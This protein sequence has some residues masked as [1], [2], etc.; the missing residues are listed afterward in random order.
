MRQCSN[1]LCTCTL[2]E[3]LERCP[4]CGTQT[5]TRFK[6]LG[7][8]S[9]DEELFEGPYTVTFKGHHKATHKAVAITVF[10]PECQLTDEEYQRLR[11]EAETMIAFTHPHIPMYIAF[12]VTPKGYVFRVKQ[13]IPFVPFSELVVD[14]VQ[15]PRMACDVL[16]SIAEAMLKMHEQDLLQPNL[17][18]SDILLQPQGQGQYHTYFNYRTFRFLQR[19][20]EEP[21]PQ[22]Q[23]LIQH[24]PDHQP[25][26]IINKQTDL[27]CLG[28][29]GYTLLTGQLFH[30]ELPRDELPPVDAAIPLGL[31]LAVMRLLQPHRDERGTLEGFL[32]TLHALTEKDFLHAEQ[33]LQSNPSPPRWSGQAMVAMVAVCAALL[34][35]LVWSIASQ[36]PTPSPVPAS[37]VGTLEKVAERSESSIFLLLQQTCTAFAI[38]KTGW[39]VTSAHC[40]IHSDI[41]QVQTLLNQAKE[42]AWH[43]MKLKNNRALEQQ[44]TYLEFVN[45]ERDWIRKL[46][47][48]KLS[49]LSAILPALYDRGAPRF[50]A[51]SP[52][53]LE[54]L[55]IVKIVVHPRYD[56]GQKRYAERLSQESYHRFLTPKDS[57]YYDLALVKVKV[58]SSQPFP[59]LS[60][61]SRRYLERMGRTRELVALHYGLGNA[62]GKET[63]KPLSVVTEVTLG[64]FRE[65]CESTTQ[66]ADQGW[67]SSFRSGPCGVQ[68]QHKE[69]LPRGASGAPLLNAKGEVVGVVSSGYTRVGYGGYNWAVRADIL[70]DWLRKQPSQ[71]QNP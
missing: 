39:L 12:G 22:L 64:V 37:Q 14:G 38:D 6:D 16:R 34:G 45:R 29:V 13:W 58:P 15:R 35:Y 66:K 62:G 54:P 26:G 68:F 53:T 21:A 2:G 28:M 11:H 31:W 33:R 8:F 43:A 32:S 7:E 61:S 55:P 59:T 47:A 4:Q 49:K 56:L 18:S 10:K 65:R 3:L 20:G 30:S 60:V 46:Q 17:T 50:Y 51:R 19:S 9:T 70:L 36:R 67:V 24:H 23:H 1:P 41:P 48:K 52:M 63:A 42:K 57:D 44:A 69:K 27:F 40:F 25:K 5:P 71:I